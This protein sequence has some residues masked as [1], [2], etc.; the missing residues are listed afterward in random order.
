[1]LKYIVWKESFSVN[2]NKLDSQ[3]KEIFNIINDLYSIVTKGKP[4]DD[5]LSVILVRLEKYTN[6]HF[7]YEENY[8]SL[9]AYP[10]LNEHKEIH[11]KFSQKLSGLFSDLDN[12]RLYHQDLMDFLKDWWLSHVAGADQ[13]YTKHAETNINNS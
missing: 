13:E 3:H 11:K 7:K 6:A 1:M 8:M 2:S 9:I 10:K 4:S 5:E 12:K